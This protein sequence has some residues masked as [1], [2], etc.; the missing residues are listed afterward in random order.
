MSTDARIGQQIHLHAIAAGKAI[1]AEWSNNRVR[2]FIEERDL[3]QLT[4]NTP[5]DQE[6]P[7][8]EIAEIRLTGYT[9][10][11][12]EVIEGLNSVASSIYDPTGNVIGALS[13]FGPSH[14]MKDKRFE[15][16]IPDLLLGATNE[17]ELNVRYS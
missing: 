17:I 15:T 3:P 5:V 4:S 2:E 13:V 12:E 16:K 14:R 6:A 10:N 9:R 8:D 7:L 11:C 1:L